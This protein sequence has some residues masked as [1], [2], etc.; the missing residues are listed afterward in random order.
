MALHDFSQTKQL[1]AAFQAQASIA[2]QQWI[3]WLGV[4]SGAGVIT[5]LSFATNLPDP[6]FALWRLLPAILSFVFAVMLAA[7][8]IL[9]R[10]WELD[11]AA[12]HFAA[13]HN[14]DDI[15]QELGNSSTVAV[16]STN[17]LRRKIS[18]REHYEKIRD[19]EHK[20]A[21]LEWKRREGFKKAQ[22]A[23]TSLSVLGFLFGAIYPISL[24]LL[25]FSFVK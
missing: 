23:T 13:A 9:L 10:S 18:E 12:A 1:V 3:T 4:G 6:D 7:V 21:E 11:A 14:R 25:H 22:F 20:E 24:I 15:Q 8:T 16:H 19:A 17:T 5:L 2:K